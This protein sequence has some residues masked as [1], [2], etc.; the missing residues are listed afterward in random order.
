M[1]KL[2]NL[3]KAN[4]P[5]KNQNLIINNLLDLPIC[6]LDDKYPDPYINPGYSN[7]LHSKFVSTANEYLKQFNTEFNYQDQDYV[8]FYLAIIFY[9]T[10]NKR[11][12]DSKCFVNDH[13]NK[14]FNRGLLILGANGVGKTFIF[15]ILSKI[16]EMNQHF[17]NSFSFISSHEVVEM[18][19]INGSAGIKH[20]Y[21]GQRYFDDVGSEETGSHYGKVEVFRNL[22]ERRHSLFMTSRQKTFIS[23]NLSRKEISDV[24]GTRVNSRINEMFNI[25]YLGGDDRRKK[26]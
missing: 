17:G 6:C 23:S 2:G 7:M 18:F 5:I 9:F 26:Q 10:R 11:F 4:Q 1:A 20:F 19:N 24:Y 25:L 15:N 8:D 14:S 13:P 22:L 12:F 3:I 21:R 16:N